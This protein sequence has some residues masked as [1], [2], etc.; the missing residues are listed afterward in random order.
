MGAN[1]S[2]FSSA[3]LRHFRLWSI[4]LICSSISRQRLLVTVTGIAQARLWGGRKVKKDTARKQAAK[5][6]KKLFFKK[7]EDNTA[8]DMV[9]HVWEGMERRHRYICISTDLLHKAQ[10]VPTGELFV[11]A[12]A[13]RPPQTGHTVHKRQISS[14]HGHGSVSRR[15]RLQVGGPCRACQ[16]TT[17]HLLVSPY[18]PSICKLPL[19]EIMETHLAPVTSPE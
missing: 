9:C 10:K 2:T 17:H 5:R 19:R 6:K 13:L 3:A 14:R 11:S 15:S 7:W 12:L 8:T 1:V 4:S 16:V 18:F